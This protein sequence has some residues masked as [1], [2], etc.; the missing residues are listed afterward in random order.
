MMEKKWQLGTSF[1]KIAENAAEKLKIFFKFSFMLAEYAIEKAY[2]RKDK[3]NK[4]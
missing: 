3:G 4:K 1:N 2:R